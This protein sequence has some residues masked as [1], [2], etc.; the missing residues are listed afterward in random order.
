MGLKLHGKFQ[1]D[2]IISALEQARI[3]D[4]TGK[5]SL[6]GGA[7]R[8]ELAVVE[9]AIEFSKELPEIERIR[10]ALSA[11]FEAGKRKL[12]IQS[13]LREA[14]RLQDKFLRK[15]AESFVVVTGISVDPFCR[16]RSIGTTRI[17]FRRSKPKR[18]DQGKI[19]SKFRHYVNSP[20]PL[21]YAFTA[22]A[23]RGR[24]NEEAFENAINALDLLRGIWNLFLNSGG[25]PRYTNGRPRPV[26]KILLAPIHTLHL[27]DGRLVDEKFWYDQGYMGAISRASISRP[28][29]IRLK[30][31]ERRVRK[32]LKDSKD[33]KWLQDV[34]VRYCRA[35]DEENFEFAFLKLWTTLEV[36]T[37]AG[38]NDTYDTTI[39]K[40]ANFFQNPDFHSQVLETLRRQRNSLVHRNESPYGLEQVV[41]RLKQYV[42]SALM[43]C[44]QNRFGFRSRA[45]LWDFLK[46][47]SDR[48]TLISKSRLYRKAIQL[49]R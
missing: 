12:T 34:I 49:R 3:V 26:N 9:S 39:K 45:E 5:V 36:L 18:F 46:L 43:I 28:D 37:G 24:S 41:Y 22:V 33:G 2:P 42:E 1:I 35:L 4:S 27:P 6:Q 11:I 38:A 15:S 23:T 44:V 8:D 13:V 16:A 19:E 10:I 48:K 20:L 31:F 17:I 14:A 32:R 25:A 40:T 30:K 47:P 7:F 29:L 21:D